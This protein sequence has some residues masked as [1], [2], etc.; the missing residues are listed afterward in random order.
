MLIPYD[1]ADFG[2]EDCKQDADSDDHRIKEYNISQTRPR[3]SKYW[4]DH[5]NSVNKSYLQYINDSH[6][7]SEAPTSFPSYGKI[8]PRHKTDKAKVNFQ[9][10]QLTWFFNIIGQCDDLIEKRKRDN[11]VS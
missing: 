3:H 9:P 2:H 1:G 10:L 4:V 7:I 5:R 6:C 11:S 8:K